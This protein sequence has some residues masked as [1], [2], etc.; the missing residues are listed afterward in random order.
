MTSEQVSK[1]EMDRV[2]QGISGSKNPDKTDR[3]AYVIARQYLK[4]LEG[5]Y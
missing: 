2:I 4:E 5:F 1:Q 3:E